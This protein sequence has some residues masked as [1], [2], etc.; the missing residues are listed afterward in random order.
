MVAVFCFVH[1]DISF[2]TYFIL[3][4][5]KPIHAHFA[6]TCKQKNNIELSVVILK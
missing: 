5:Y 1:K 3:L 6:T 2:I 4:D